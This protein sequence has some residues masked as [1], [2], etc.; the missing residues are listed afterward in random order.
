MT[1]FCHPSHVLVSGVGSQE[2][3]AMHLETNAWIPRFT[4]FNW[5]DKL[6]S[7]GMTKRHSS[8]VCASIEGEKHKKL[9]YS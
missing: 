5:D 2:K 7:T 8:S 9:F 3:L 6:K 4:S 1:G